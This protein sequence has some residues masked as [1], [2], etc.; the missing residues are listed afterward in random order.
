MVYWWSGKLVEFKAPGEAEREIHI[1]TVLGEVKKRDYQNFDSIVIQ[2]IYYK[3]QSYN[4][5]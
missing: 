5:E 3:A 1:V 4:Y 2:K